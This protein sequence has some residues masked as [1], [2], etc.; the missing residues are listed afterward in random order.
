[1]RNNIFISSTYQDLQ[2]H[3]SQIWNV[4]QNF[5]INVV[6]MENFGARKSKPL[7]TC[8]AEISKCQIYIG[9]ISM[10][11]G[12]IDEETGKSYTQLEYDKAKELGIEILIY[13]V[14]EKSGELKTGHIDFGDK[15]L[16]LN[17]FKNILKNNHT[18]DF[19]I[20]ETDLGQKIYRDLEKLI[21]KQT[22]TTLRPNKLDARAFHIELEDS[23]WVIFIGYLKGKP[24]EVFSASTDED[25][26][27]LLPKHVDTGLL[28]KEK[29]EHGFRYDF[30]FLNK[31]GFKIT[32]EGI[33]FA[34]GFFN[35]QI[36]RYSS[37]I[38][39]LLQQN[40]NL[41]AIIEIIQE[42]RF[43][44]KRYKNWKSEIIR[45]LKK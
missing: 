15:N 11:Y 38:S 10:C 17:N 7:D 26:G 16:R 33:D 14:D 42:M 32:I 9:I 44:D 37:I 5:D 24:F 18:V 29:T 27:I 4:L 22:T 31:R 19:F 45:L 21:S 6:G 39:K 20:N 40:I 2:L 35:F 1:M 28:I 36:G 8:L 3:R 23:S 30:H 34:S 13:L 43:E 41:N 12:S 25:Y